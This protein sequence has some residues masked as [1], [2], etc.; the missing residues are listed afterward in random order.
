MG[1]S[2]FQCIDKMAFDEEDVFHALVK[3]DPMKSCGPDEVPGR[4]LK[5]GATST[6]V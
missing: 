3:T 5:M 2:S 4:L 1:G 6:P